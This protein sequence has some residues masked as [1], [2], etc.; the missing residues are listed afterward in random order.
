[1][2]KIGIL[3]YLIIALSTFLNAQTNVLVIDYNNAFSSDQS[4]N[5]SN[6]YN[7]LL[8]TQTSVTRV[9]AIPGTISQAQYEQ[10]W[11]FGNMGVPT[12]AL[13]APIVTYMNNGGA[14]YIQSE[15]SCCNNQAAYADQLI[16][17]TVTVGGSISHNMMKSGNYEY[18]LYSPLKC[19]PFF[20]HGAAV[21]PF[22]GATQEHILYEATPTCGSPITTGDV[23]GVKFKS[24]DMITGEGALVVNGDFNIFPIGGAC[25]SVGILGTP[26]NND[27]I[28]II[29]EM[30]PALACSQL[31]N[32]GGG[33]LTC[34]ANPPNFC[35]ST[36][37]GWY[38]TGNPGCPILG[39]DTT[40]HYKWTV[41]SGEPMNV[42]FNFSCDTCP[43]PTASPSIQTTYTLSITKGDTNLN[44][45]R[46]STVIP[47]TVTPGTQPTYAGLDTTIC[48]G[49]SV[50]IGGSPTATGPGPFT[51]SWTPSG[52][53]NN[54][55]LANPICTP[56]ALGSITYTVQAN[57]PVCSGYDSITV[58]AISCCPVNIVDTVVANVSCFGFCDGSVQIT[59]N[60]GATQ[61]SIDGIN[62]QPSNT[63][64]N[65]CPGQHT[66]YASDGNC[67]DS[68]IITIT[69][70]T[71]I[72]V[73]AVITDASCA[74][75]SDGQ[76]VVT[77]LGGTPGYTYSWTVGGVGNSPTASNL[78][79][80]QHTVTITDLNGCSLD[81][82][83][84]VGQP[85]PLNLGSF[86]GDILAGCSPLNVEFT[87]TTNPATFVSMFW[88]LG[89]GATSTVNPTSTTY[90]TP[91]T[92]D[93][94]LTIT[95]AM[96]CQGVVEKLAYITVYADP[97]AHFTANPGQATVFDPTYYF[98]DLSQYNIAS[99][100]WNFNNLGT[101]N[102]QNPIF[103]FPADTG[104]HNVSLIVVDNH[105]C[106]DTVSHTV[107]VKGEYGVFVPNAFTPD[108][109]NKNDGFSP[110][111]FGISDVGYS[112]L[113]F[114]RWGEKM[115]E[116]TDIN[117]LW[118]GDYKNKLVPNGVYVW[119]LN[120]KDLNGHGH[121]QVGKVTVVK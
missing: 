115:F 50:T 104:T 37:L 118:Y 25:N 106:I 56:T 36:L 35:G 87:N 108:F 64:N 78:P 77:P 6:I 72:T 73:S 20:S 116:T 70:P 94:K 15:V 5:N 79:A 66:V 84:T 30:L 39:C 99:W 17:A 83:F 28:D 16:D 10:V 103:T 76:I 80:G 89:N 101:S 75:A 29:A 41:V 54:N 105:G 48:L 47:I 120:F 23:V 97:I 61:Y 14:V 60:G 45:P 19:V 63:F 112:F 46:S 93:V 58:T 100:D 65:L 92:Y 32:P 88:E 51:Y 82:T 49:Q 91:G 33:T 62:W 12:P 55:T 52:D 117:T 9:N 85:A 71:A 107:I 102:E 31:T 113:I 74:G 13:L 3:L 40:T 11:I 7:R 121:S 21:R 57:G 18:Q 98:I 1:M 68:L 95:D 38:Y 59:A 22:V 53:L 119:K 114:D 26:N 27:V 96:G 109:D 2:K 110:K 90:D 111:G 69:E 43:Y 86:E 67:P 8:A 34:T 42:P 44:C 81:S 24:C 4:N